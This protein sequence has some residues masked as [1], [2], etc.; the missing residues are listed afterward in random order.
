[1]NGSQYFCCVYK[2]KLNMKKFLLATFALMICATMMAQESYKKAPSLGVHFI[3]NDFETAS[4][5]RT[6]NLAKVLRDKEW[7][8]ITRMTGGMALSFTQGFSEHIDFNAA[9]AASFVNYPVPNKVN[10]GQQRLLL[11]LAATANLK[12]LTDQYWVNPFITAG[13]GASK[14]SGYYAAFAPVGLGI[15]VKMVEGTYAL[16]N[17]Q[18]RIPVTDNAAYHFYHSIGFIQTIAKPK[19]PA[20]VVVPLPV[21]ADRDGDGIV[22]AEDKCPDQAG[23]ATLQGCPDRDGDGIADGDDKCPDVAGLA[24]YQGCPIPDTDGDGINDEMDKCPTVKG[25]ARYQGCPVPDT[26]NDGVNDEEDKCPT[27]PGPASNQGCP[28]IAK[29]VIEKVSMAAKNVFFST[30]SYKLLSKSFK[31]LN[32][33]ADILKADES[34]MIDIDGHTDAVG[35][36]ESNHTLSHNRANAVK[37]YLVSKGI[38]ESRMKTTGYGEEKPVAD[39]DTAAGRA[40]NRRTEMTVRN[41]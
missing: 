2:T 6:F 34:L 23:L 9:L 41:F 24:K 15:Q 13:I 39:N 14:Y 40:K 7:S 20:P 19:A 32:E 12:L 29:E 37:E 11:E 36:D 10:D 18:Y 3:L 27:R 4:D 16:L 22:D 33:V 28:E 21:V 31:S 30:G 17:S 5:I 38:D 26:D 1:M 8:K 35:S 25:V